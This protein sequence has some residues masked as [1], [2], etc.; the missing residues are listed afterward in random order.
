MAKFV[1]GDVVVVPFPFSDL[2]Q[3]KRRPAL[4]VSVLEGDDLILCQVTSQLVKDSYAIS[5]EGRDFEEGGLKQ[6]SN[7]R[8]NRLFT[9]DGHIVLYRIG[10][11]KKD[12]LNEII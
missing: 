7:V 3:A 2:T 5:I 12:K 8:P 10:N 4:V 9:A 11:L 1:K 6:K